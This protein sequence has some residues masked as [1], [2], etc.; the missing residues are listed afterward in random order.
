MNED[1][2]TRLREAISQCAGTAGYDA[3]ETLCD[4]EYEVLPGALAEIMRLR[5]L[6]HRTV[7][8]TTEY[9]ASLQWQGG[10]YDWE[11]IEPTAE[12]IA[13]MERVQAHPWCHRCERILEPGESMWTVGHAVYCDEHWA[14]HKERQE[15]RGRTVIEESDG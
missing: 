12:E 7:H 2:T 13:V 11:S 14:E 10:G 6:L 4:L 1:I 5:N 3:S 8:L 15:A 9:G